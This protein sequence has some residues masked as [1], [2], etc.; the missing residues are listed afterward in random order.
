[1]APPPP[2]IILIFVIIFILI[3][4]FIR[5]DAVGNVL[6]SS[7]PERGG[8]ERATE[9]K[10]PVLIRRCDAPIGNTHGIHFCSERS[11]L[12]R[13]ILRLRYARVAAFTSLRMTLIGGR[14]N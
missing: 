13:G 3:L 14:D 4:I 2:F 11:W 12:L 8:E 10:D 7:H 5:N 9:S 6:T 1:M